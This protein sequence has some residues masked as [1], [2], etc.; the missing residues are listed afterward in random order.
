MVKAKV[1]S[2]EE[3]ATFFD[4]EVSREAVDKAFEEVYNE[5]TKI[6]N[7]P[8]FRVGKA[9]K[10]LVRKH[11]TDN[12][13]EEVL[14]RLIPDAYRNILSE[15]K[16]DPVGLP[17]ISDIS[18]EEGKSLSFKARVETRPKF[19]LKDYKGIKIEKKKVVMKDEDIDKTLE[20][21]REI[22]AKY[23]TVEG[24]P[25]EMG[26]YTV[27]DVDCFVCG[28]P[29]HKKRENLWLSIDKDS[30]PPGLTEKMV[31]MAKG[32][33][34]DIE[35]VLPEKYPIKDAAGKTAIY[36]VKVKEIKSRIL[37]NLDGD[38]AK[39]LGKDNLQEVKKEIASELEKKA[40]VST[41]VDLENQLLSK[42]MDGNNFQVPPSLVR[43]QLNFMVED[44]KK[45]LVEKGFKKE[46]LD[47]KDKEFEEKFKEDALRYVR[48][49][50]ILERIAND[51]N[52]NV[53]KVDLEESYKSIAAQTGATVEKVKDYYSKEDLVDNLTDKVREE[54][55]IK[56]LLDNANITEKQV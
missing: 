21:L 25:L 29:I 9:P 4:I 44:S 14:K 2:Q 19:K 12:A 53:E 39:D 26:D 6:A 50:F 10:G 18:F 52:I 45:R 31:G 23:I 48:L 28:K 49:M 36:H 5:I 46:D 34:R 43:K 38:F 55:T 37:P 7:I 13:K 51:E 42:L 17:E 32:E 15:H 22:N 8:G 56:F 1:K 20:N 3:C 41:E 47:K 16:L 54:K 35:V 30:F 40:K 11:Y 24:R 27:S 33:E